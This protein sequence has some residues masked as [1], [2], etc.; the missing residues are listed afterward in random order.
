MLLRAS[1]MPAQRGSSSPPRLYDAAVCGRGVGWE[2]GRAGGTEGRRDGGREGGR[3]DICLS[4]Y[5]YI[6]LSI[7]M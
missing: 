2:G 5:L 7:W 3:E 4:I 1:P 6:Y